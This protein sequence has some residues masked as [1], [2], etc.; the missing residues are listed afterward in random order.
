[1]VIILEVVETNIPILTLKMGQ[2]AAVAADLSARGS[3]PSPSHVKRGRGDSPYTPIEVP[4]R[5]AW[6]RATSRML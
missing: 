3:S 4:N 6:R 1:M 2:K 5:L